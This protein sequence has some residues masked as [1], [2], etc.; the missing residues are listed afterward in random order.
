MNTQ[1]QTLLDC[2]HPES[3]HSSFT[4]G[5]GQDSQGKKH[6]YACCAEQDKQ[7]MREHGKI[8]LYL[9]QDKTGSNRITNWPNS[10]SFPVNHI[11]KGR[12]NIASCRYDCWFSFEGQQW[13]GV[14][15]GDN[16]QIIHCKRIKG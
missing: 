2:G 15:F 13:H 10:L 12:H 5:Y 16:T 11:R 4:R 1:A 14:Q 7:H 6:C 8:A 3:E 9:V